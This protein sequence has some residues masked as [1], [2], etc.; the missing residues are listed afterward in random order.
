M[1]KESPIAHIKK[2]QP[3]QG[4][5]LPPIS[6]YLKEFHLRPSLPWLILI[7]IFTKPTKKCLAAIVPQF[8]Q[9][10]Y[11]GLLMSSMYGPI[12]GDPGPERS[13]WPGPV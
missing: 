13:A 7:L 2:Y 12:Q 9:R 4:G 1:N 3:G 5:R 11:C 6:K 8:D 10:Q